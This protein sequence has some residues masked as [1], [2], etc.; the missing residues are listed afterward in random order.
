MKL[1]AVIACC[2]AFQIILAS[3]HLVHAQGAPVPNI[4]DAVR[5]ADETRKGAPL[6]QT[7]A[8]PVLP[9]LLDPPFTLK[10]NTRLLVRSIR[11]EGQGPV[12]ESELRPILAD[13]ENRKLTLAEIYEAADKITTLY[14]SQGYLVAKAYVPAQDARKGVLRF[15]IVPGRY[16]AIALKNE[17]LVHDD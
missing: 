7:G 3:T 13:Y 8:E 16:G 9:R 4:G 2:G 12:A 10:D 1:S 6:P 15:K 11:I 14:R 17:S 5:Q